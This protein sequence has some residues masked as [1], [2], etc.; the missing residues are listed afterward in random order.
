VYTIA[1]KVGFEF[2]LIQKQVVN[3]AVPDPV[4][5]LAD[6]NQALNERNP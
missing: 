1:K 4:V 6:D 2:L 5:A 3:G